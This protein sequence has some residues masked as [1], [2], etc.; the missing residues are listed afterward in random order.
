MKRVLKCVQRKQFENFP[1]SLL[2][3][4]SSLWSL[5]KMEGLGEVRG[6]EGGMEPEFHPKVHLKLAKLNTSVH[7]CS[8]WKNPPL[9]KTLPFTG[10][11]NVCL[12]ISNSEGGAQ[13][14]GYYHS[15]P[16]GKM[17]VPDLK[18][19]CDLDLKTVLFEIKNPYRS[20]KNPYR[21]SVRL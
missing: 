20:T 19:M 13:K 21:R 16:Y 3:V 4:T 15:L 14:N 10:A 7:R 12:Q 5:R 17:Y 11:Q 8:N 18:P 9:E 2:R 1:N 6:A